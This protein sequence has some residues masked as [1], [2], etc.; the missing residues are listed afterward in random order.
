MKNGFEVI[1]TPLEG[2]RITQEEWVIENDVRRAIHFSIL[3]TRD[4]QTRK[5]L[6]ALGWTPPPDKLG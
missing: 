5:A 1:T 2:G 3:N 6:I 4:E